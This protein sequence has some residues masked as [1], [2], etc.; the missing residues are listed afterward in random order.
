M[1]LISLNDFILYEVKPDGACLFRSLSNALYLNSDKNI[2]NLKLKFLESGYFNDEYA[3]FLKDFDND[4]IECFINQDNDCLEDELEEEIARGLQ[5]IILN[6]I[7][8]NADID[9]N[10]ILMDATGEKLLIRDLVLAV[11]GHSMEE[12]LNLYEIFA[13]DEDFRKK[14]EIDEFGKEYEK[15][16]K[17][18]DRWGGTLEIIIFAHLF[19]INIKV[20]ITQIYDNRIKKY[21]DNPTITAKNRQNILLNRV[22]TIRCLRK[23]VPEFNLLLRTLSL[24]SHYDFLI[25]KN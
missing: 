20:F 13:G 16:E 18:A 2:G 6:Y 22:E 7:G 19:N 14:I 8:R 9:V 17:V 1:E 5:K 15:K 12:Y 25:H 3:D 23:G 10:S 21:R 4:I 24:G 11:H